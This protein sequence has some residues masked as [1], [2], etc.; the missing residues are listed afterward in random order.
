M[1]LGMDLDKAIARVTVNP[2]KV[3]DY[4]VELGTLRPG[5]EA[6]IGI[7]ELRQENVEFLDSSREKR[8]GTRD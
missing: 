4:G 7:F 8:R 6:N 3:F 5:S 1:A 2:A